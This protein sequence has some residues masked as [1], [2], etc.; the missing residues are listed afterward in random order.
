MVRKNQRLRRGV[1]PISITGAY[2][3]DPNLEGG[4]ATMMKRRNAGT[5]REVAAPCGT[6]RVVTSIS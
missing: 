5:M 6:A 3:H 1:Q 4:A 2:F